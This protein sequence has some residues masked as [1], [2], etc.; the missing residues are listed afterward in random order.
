MRSNDM[1]TPEILEAHGYRIFGEGVYGGIVFLPPKNNDFDGSFTLYKNGDVSFDFFGWMDEERIDASHGHGALKMSFC[2]TGLTKFDF[3]RI[4]NAFGL[5]SLSLNCE[6]DNAN[7]G[8]PITIGSIDPER[9]KIQDIRTEW[10]DWTI[11]SK[12][13]ISITLY[14]TT[15]E[16]SHRASTSYEGSNDMF[17]AKVKD[18]NTAQFNTLCEVFELNERL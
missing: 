15:T 13:N 16:V 7:N 3:N 5:H 12:G 11:C 9:W 18:L 10:T 1:L 17:E 8:R 2:K 4:A 14:E 6:D